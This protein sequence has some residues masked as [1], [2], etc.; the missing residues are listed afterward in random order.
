MHNKPALPCLLILSQ[1][2]FGSHIDTYFRCKYLRHRYNVI[3]I[4]WDYSIPKQSMTDV[5]T[6]YISRDGNIITRNLRY[7]Y[8]AFTWLKNNPCDI[9]VIKY[10]RGCSFIKLLFPRLSFVFDVRTGSVSKH[11]I[12]RKIYDNFLTF[13][14]YFFQ[15]V[16]AISDSLSKKLNLTNKTEIIPLGSEPI[17]TI[18]KSFDSLHLL[19]VG[20][21]S[22]RDIDKT[23]MAF[24]KF[25]DNYKNDISMS[26]TIIGDGPNG[27]IDFLK[28]IVEKFSLSS[29]VNIAG[30]IPFTDLGTYF[31]SHNIGVSFVPITDYFDAQP[32][33]KN[34]DYLLSG[35]PVIA[36]ATSEN[37]KVITE[38]NG[39]L[40]GDSIDSFYEGMQTIWD[41][42]KCYNS[43]QIADH[44]SQYTWENI[45][46]NLGDYLDTIRKKPIQNT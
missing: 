19:Y 36:T 16:T 40:V 33:T 5:K 20:T 45:V 27:E 22:R 42:I 15:H 44:S 32:V 23:L 18:N 31:D 46:N 7:I 12:F 3:I 14:S 9:C 37:K 30:R 26:Y 24:S 13:E 43:E 34:F 21:L 39:V 25:Y 8:A 29:V 4:C 10:F 41:N 17:S 6:L 11:Y 35:M 2:Q 28:D 1:S 38:S